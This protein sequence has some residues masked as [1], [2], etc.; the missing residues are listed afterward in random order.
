MHFIRA[1]SPVFGPKLNGRRSCVTRVE[2]SWSHDD[3]VL[4][5]WDEEKSFGKH[6]KGESVSKQTLAVRY[7][8]HD[9]TPRPQTSSLLYSQA[10]CFSYLPL[11]VL[12]L[13]RLGSTAE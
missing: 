11:G 4:A 10:H 7:L 6:V 13:W 2:N 12:L 1:T 5:S 8:Q 9:P 3:R